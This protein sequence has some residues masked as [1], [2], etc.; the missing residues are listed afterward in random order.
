[1][2]DNGDLKAMSL[3]WRIQK[4]RPFS[5]ALVVKKVVSGRQK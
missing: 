3:S 4:G 1:L 2:A 5:V